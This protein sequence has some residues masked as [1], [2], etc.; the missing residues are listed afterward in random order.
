MFPEQL[1]LNLGFFFMGQFGW[2]MLLERG[3]VGLYP[4]P[5]HWELVLVGQAHPSWN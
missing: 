2:D 1:A 5:V 4:E 3:S